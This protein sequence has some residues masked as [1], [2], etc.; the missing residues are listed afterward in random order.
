MKLYFL[1]GSSDGDFSKKGLDEMARKL[2]KKTEV[3]LSKRVSA[4][5]MVNYRRMLF[6]D[7]CAEVVDFS[8]ALCLRLY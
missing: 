8:A 3:A 6:T 2:T 7:A 5:E 4:G 1:S